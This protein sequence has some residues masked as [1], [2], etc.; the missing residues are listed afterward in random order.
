MAL[1]LPEQ[2]EQDLGR[3]T[4]IFPIVEIGNIYISTNAYSLDN[5]FY[6]PLLL[7]IPSLKESI[8]LEKRNYKISSVNLSIS[9]YKYE[10]QRFSELVSG[11]LINTPVKIYWVSQSN[12][13]FLIYNGIVRRYEIGENIKIT[14]EDHSQKS[15]HQDLPKQSIPISS[16]FKD[17]GKK[18][19]MVFGD[20]DRS[21]CVIDN[22]EIIID[23]EDIVSLKTNIN[24][25]GENES[26]VYI[27]EDDSY[28]NILKTI[29]KDFTEGGYEI[30]D[31]DEDVDEGETYTVSGDQWE[32]DNSTDDDSTSPKI[33]I[34]N[35][36]LSTRGILQC[37]MLHGA[38]SVSYT[39][40]A[41]DHQ[42]NVFPPEVAESLS[43]KDFET[44]VAFEHTSSI[45]SYTSHS[46]HR[47]HTMA[48]MQI[49]TDPNISD[50]A[51]YEKEGADDKIASQTQE[52]K[53]NGITLPIPKF[54]SGNDDRIYYYS[55]IYS[56]HGAIG[57]R[58]RLDGIAPHDS[59]TGETIYDLTGLFGFPE[60]IYH[61][62]D[63][64]AYSDNIYSP[65]GDIVI[66][67]SIDVKYGTVSDEGS[68]IGL[69]FYDWCGMGST[70]NSGKYMIYYRIMHDYG[71]P[72]DD[73]EEI[74]YALTTDG[75]YKE[76]EIKSL[77]DVKN[78]FKK[79]FYVN[80][81]GSRGI[82][83][84]NIEGTNWV[85]YKRPTA[86]TAIKHIL[87]AEL[88]YNNITPP[89]DNTYINWLYDFTVKDTIDS[90]KL[91][92][93]I[94][95]ASALIPRF[96]YNGDFKLDVIPKEGG[97]TDHT[98][99]E[100]Q[101]ISF[102]S[103]RTKPEDIYTK[104]E[105]KYHWDYAR[106]EFDK[107]I[108][109]I[110]VSDL[111]PDY[112]FDY[113]GIKDDHSESTLI[114]DD[115]RGKY[116]RHD[117]T[118][119]RFASWLL[120]WHC[121]QHLKIKIKLSLSA[122][123]KIEIGDLVKFD[124]L[125]DDIEPYGID[126]TDTDLING[127][128]FYSNFMVVSTNKTLDSVSLE[129]IQMHQMLYLG[130]EIIE[131][132]MDTT[133]INFNEDANQPNDSCV[134][135]SELPEPTI[136]EISYENSIYNDIV[137]NSDLFATNFYQWGSKFYIT[138]SIEITFQST[139]LGGAYQI[140]DNANI[141]L[142]CDNDK[143]TVA[144]LSN[145]T[146]IINSDTSTGK[147]IVKYFPDE[148]VQSDSDWFFE[149]EDKVDG[150]EFTINVKIDFTT[151]FDNQYSPQFVIN[152]K[153][154]EDTSETMLGDMNG[155]GGLNVVDL[156]QL[157]NLAAADI[158]PNNQPPTPQ[159]DMNGD[160]GCNILDVVTLANLIMGGDDDIPDLGTDE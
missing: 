6:K 90:K 108:E 19:P 28:L 117:L 5:K 20:V 47:K 62:P 25:F 100:D 131:G 126:Y 51:E 110:V 56:N 86:Y 77:L 113:Y 66:S 133:A 103:T 119:K 74:D 55:D 115:D 69:Y 123:L 1:V 107:E 45:T 34:K 102:S 137:I 127:Q 29:E 159:A 106:E 63:Y 104:I 98:I 99:Y 50:T 85:I 125:L 160:G 78:I 94:A 41:E 44:D 155:D 22:R 91:I 61:S 17:A 105:F 142:S 129:L 71:S 150:E 40:I 37:K 65:D 58:F 30:A 149:Y 80:V 53:L 14:V 96:D 57:T 60:M 114:I 24:N 39:T 23:T 81:R 88:D 112:K 36:L 27:N 93:N 12:I 2:F 157:S 109:P 59:H 124:S 67:Y 7:N 68:C 147:S 21:P 128:T 70:V 141:E 52:I 11:S 72:S 48:T 33:L 18:I 145:I 138:N 139:L 16:N 54:A 15:L 3:N 158:F 95:S 92:E 83:E 134:F 43:D 144:D 31:T 132:C 130:E 42:D 9:N 87:S 35:T 120:S 8:D 122:G 13:P 89:E 49:F 26:S 146:P 97:T 46:Y 135:A 64:P 121:N 79:D 151:N 4:N 148:S 154:I 73:D 136:T 101:I 152:Y 153:Y 10:G 76:I 38:S 140:I 118:A 156:V 32:Q 82:R 111:F 84:E 75:K 143:I 116:I